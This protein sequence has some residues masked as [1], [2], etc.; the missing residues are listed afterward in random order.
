MKII[1]TD[2]NLI[3]LLSNNFGESKMAV[4]KR[5]TGKRNMQYEKK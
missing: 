1:V 2:A 5:C 4:K 3:R